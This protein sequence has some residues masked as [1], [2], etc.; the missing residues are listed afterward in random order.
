MS[1]NVRP[2]LLSLL[3]RTALIS[4]T[5]LTGLPLLAQAETGVR[6]QFNLPAASLEESLNR[7]AQTAGITLPVNPALVDGRQANTL[8]GSY[9]TT[10]AF[11]RLLA[12]SGLVAKHEGGNR[13]SLQVVAQGA[14]PTLSMVSVSGKAIGSTTE[15]TGSYTTESTSSSTRLNLSLQETPQPITVI[16]RQRMEDQGLN[17]LIEILDAT[18]GVT[19]KGFG[20]G[21][22]A[23]QMVARGASIGNFQIDGIPSSSSMSNYLQ[24]SVIYDRVEVVKG[25]TGMMSGLG[26]PSATINMM[27]KRPTG[28]ALTDV[29]LE[30]GTWSRYG[31]G[32]DVSRA[33]NED[34][35]VRG[36]LVADYKNQDLWTD[37]YNQEYRVL[38]GIGEVDLGI[39]TLFTLG[40]SHITRDTDAPVRSFPILYSNRQ[41]TGATPAHGAAPDWSYYNHQHNNVFS[42]LEHTFDSGWVAKAEISHSRYKYDAVIASLGGAVDAVTGLGTFVQSPHWANEAEQTSVDTYITGPF[43]LFGRHHEVIAGITLS[44]L[45]QQSPGYNVVRQNLTNSFNWTNEAERPVHTQTSR[46]KSQEQQYGAY[47]STRLQLTDATSLLLGGRF[48]DWARERKSLTL[49]TGSLSKTRDSEHNVAIPYVGLVHALNDT[50]SLYSSY[51]KIFNPQGNGVRDVNNMPLDPEEGVG[52]EAGIKASLNEERLNASLSLFRTDRDNLA[53]WSSAQFAYESLND[54]S[55][56]GVEIEINGELMPGWQFSSGYTYSETT[57]QHGNRIMTR[58]PRNAVKLF[59]S[60]RL[61][62]NWNKLTLGGGVNWESK[63]GDPLSVYTQ[64]NYAVTNLMAR[65]Q[66]NKQLSITGHLNNALDKEYYVAVAA[67]DGAYGSPRNFMISAKYSF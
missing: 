21:A 2:T 29:T 61:P 32:V 35:T 19:V 50:W 7:L 42:S 46:S 12:G 31:A 56:E 26:T 8:S 13:W 36:R 24:S 3:I 55:T 5:A 60:Y 45:D 47:I 44:D 15:G 62:G 57:N 66:V 23:P 37:T 39:N 59:T 4:S 64:E 25:A 16:T 30:G 27:R 52:Y 18:I 9:T 67:T 53:Q 51:T 40:F 22:D 6:Q 49:A 54:A 20:V 33:L 28:E 58:I 48:T 14:A 34:A 41:A 10:E 17:N 63:T 43:S 38:Y 11:D 65:Y 1:T